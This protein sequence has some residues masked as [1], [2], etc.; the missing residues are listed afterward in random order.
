[1]N[2]YGKNNKLNSTIRGFNT[3]TF[4]GDVRIDNHFGKNIFDK[5]VISYKN[6]KDE[7]YLFNKT[8]L[9]EVLRDILIQEITLLE[10]KPLERFKEN[11]LNKIDF[12]IIRL[13]SELESYY[14]TRINDIVERI[15]VK[16]ID[17]EIEKRVTDKLN[18]KLEEIKKFLNE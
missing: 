8:E 18:I 15:C 7:E 5:K 3:N 9:T 10:D 6:D 16:M 13:E 2:K 14:E 4:N 1:M 11:L 17:S 12:L